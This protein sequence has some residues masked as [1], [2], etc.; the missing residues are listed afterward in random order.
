MVHLLLPKLAMAAYLRDDVGAT[1]AAVEASIEGQEV[2]PADRQSAARSAL[3]SGGRGCVDVPRHDDAV[4]QII[5]VNMGGHVI[6]VKRD[7]FLQLDGNKLSAMVSRW[8]S[9]LDRDEAGNVFFDY[10][11]EVM[12]PLIEWLRELRDTIPGQPVSPAHVQEPYRL[13]FVKM[14]LCFSFPGH[15]LREAGVGADELRRTAGYD[16]AQ[17]REMGFRAEQLKAD[18][19]DYRQLIKAGFD[20][21]ELRAAGFDP[22][23]LRERQLIDVDAVHDD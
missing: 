6:Q 14:M 12:M 20:A 9:G 15:H 2:N 7:L 10:S 22:R 16:A 13:A 3:A 1:A 23:Q 17:L 18:G 19:F 4:P 21:Q 8:W 5:G 11:P